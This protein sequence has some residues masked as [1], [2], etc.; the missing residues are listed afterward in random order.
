[1]QR[2]TRNENDPV[3]K[4]SFDLSSLK[5]SFRSR[6][7]QGLPSQEQLNSVFLQ[8]LFAKRTACH[9][10]KIQLPGR[11]CSALW[12]ST[13]VVHCPCLPDPRAGIFLPMVAGSRPRS[14]TAADTRAIPEYWTGL[15]AEQEATAR[16][17]DRFAERQKL[18][19][20]KT[21]SRARRA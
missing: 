16:R 5:A 18:A 15:I 9:K 4:N 12:P 17:A 11:I 10:P 7:Q 1:M 21:P 2:C 14:G 3:G 20:I 8:P 6:P 13:R 19:T